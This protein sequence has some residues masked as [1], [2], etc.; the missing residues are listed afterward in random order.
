M[1]TAATS[2]PSTSAKQS[3]EKRGLEGGRRRHLFFNWL[4]TGKMAPP[5]GQA[6]KNSTCHWPA[7]EEARGRA[8]VEA[9]R[10]GERQREL[11]DLSAPS[12]RSEEATAASQR[13]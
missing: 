7:P 5:T 1:T 10:R 9:R 12:L 13:A 8:R 4:P 6:R 2:E 3:A 11:E